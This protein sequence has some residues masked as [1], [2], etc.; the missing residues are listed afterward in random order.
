MEKTSLPLLHR[1]DSALKKSPHL[2]GRHLLPETNEGEV[3]LRGTVDSYFQKQMA[4][5]VLRN[6][7]GIDRIRNQLEVVSERHQVL[8]GCYQ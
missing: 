2:A 1:V 3:I 7:E 5:E 8:A 6:I 4:Q